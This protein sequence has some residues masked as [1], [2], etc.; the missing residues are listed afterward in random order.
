MK[1]GII[2]DHYLPWF[3][4]GNQTSFQPNL[5]YSPITGSND[6]KRS[7]H[8]LLTKGCNHIYSPLSSSGLQG[9]KPLSSW[10]P[11]ITVVFPIVHARFVHI[12]NR[13]I[14]ITSQL[15]YE[16]LPFRLI[17]FEVAVGLFF[18]V[19]PIFFRAREIVRSLMSSCHSCAIS[20][21]V[22]SP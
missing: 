22:L 2:H 11:A 5:E 20:T 4:H 21:W 14:R 6:R 15:L 9:M 10:V 1:R 18:R 7:H 13:F 12:N 8:L 19:N 3:E 17:P 16:P